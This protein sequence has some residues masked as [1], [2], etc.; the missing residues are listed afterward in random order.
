MQP[1]YL[2]WMGYFEMVAEVDIFVLLDNVQFEKK[3]W[4]NRNRI[5]AKSGELILTVPTDTSKKFEQQ[6]KDVK[7]TK[8]SGFAKKH[9]KSISLNYSRSKFFEKYFPSIC[10]LISNNNMSLS[11]LNHDL[12]VYIASQLGITTEIIRA[13]HLDASGKSTKL[14]VAQCIELGASE[15]YAAKGSRQYVSAERDFKKHGIQVI[16]QDYS[17]PIYPQLHGE[18]IPNLSA[19]DLLFNCGEKS[20]EMILA[21]PIRERT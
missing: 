21:K 18:F 15:F 7:I 3:S 1:T 4:Q 12:I 13:S 20:L 19:I 14:T 9:L 10:E 8:D 11:D 5:K 17:H 2:P 16:F 6:I